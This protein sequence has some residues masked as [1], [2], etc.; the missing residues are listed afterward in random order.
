MKKIFITDYIKN[1]IIEKKIFK[2]FAEVICLSQVN[3]KKFINNI[4]NSDGLLVWHS[5][6]SKEVIDKLIKCKAVVRYGVGY[7][8]IDLKYL[9]EKKILFANT[10]DY[11]TEEVADTTCALILN[12]VRKIKFYDCHTKKKLNEW[13]QEVINVNKFNPIKRTSKNKLG[14]IGLGRIG[15]SVA[16][17][18]KAFGFDIGFYDPYV[19][20]GYEKVL[21]I[22]RFE[23]LD[24]LISS[25][26]IISINAALNNETRNMIDSNFIS[27]INDNCI[28][29]N[30]ARGEII[31]DTKVVLDGMKNGKI[32]AIGLDVLPKE[33]P[34]KQDPLISVWIDKKNI[35]SNRIIINPHSAYYSSES[36]IEMREKAS[37]NL[38]NFLKGKKLRNVIN[39]NGQN[40]FRA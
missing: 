13:Q 27:K 32:G 20:S 17:R 7:E 35:L 29:V 34:K 39:F 23:S 24:Q 31:K 2:G 28:I 40:I 33:P 18:L 10:P 19:I 8:N 30:T 14:I 36:I 5:K 1:P 6:I 26:S 38:L 22:K 15:S 4:K 25:S 37:L 9:T 16:L 12:L 11:G 3:K 21:K